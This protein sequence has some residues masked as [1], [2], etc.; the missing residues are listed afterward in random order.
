MYEFLVTRKATEDSNNHV[1]SLD[2]LNFSKP[3]GSSQTKPP[4]TDGPRTEP[5]G[6]LCAPIWISAG[7]NAFFTT[8][9]LQNLLIAIL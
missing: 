5:E 1:T 9:D 2:T 6:M 3:R 8:C 7:K 4:P